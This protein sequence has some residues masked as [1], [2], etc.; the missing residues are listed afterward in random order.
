MHLKLDHRPLDCLCNS[1][2]YDE[3]PRSLGFF[4]SKKETE[5]RDDAAL[6][7]VAIMMREV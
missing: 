1:G 2:Q 4:G 3:E 5:S 6:C 7:G